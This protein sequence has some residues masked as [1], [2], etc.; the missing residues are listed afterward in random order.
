LASEQVL[1]SYY[2]RPKSTIPITKQSILRDILDM[3]GQDGGGSVRK[4][5]KVVCPPSGAVLASRLM[6]LGKYFNFCTGCSLAIVFLSARNIIGLHDQNRPAM[7]MICRCSGEQQPWQRNA[8]PKRLRTGAQPR[9]K[10]KYL[11]RIVD[12]MICCLLES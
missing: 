3:R 2:C 5:P 12:Y 11:A 9:A 1:P 6:L 10:R 4:T 7:T 8:T